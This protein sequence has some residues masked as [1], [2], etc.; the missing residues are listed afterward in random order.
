MDRLPRLC[1]SLTRLGV[2]FRLDILGVGPAESH[3]R[4]E[5]RRFP[6]S[7]LGYKTGASYW[8]HLGNWDMIVFVSDVEGLGISA[9]EGMSVGVLPLYPATGGA[10]PYVSKVK[11]SLLYPTGDIDALS[12][13]IG[14]LR[15][16]PEHEIAELRSRCR[17]VIGP[18]L[19]DNYERFFLAFLKET[20]DRER[21]SPERL[22][23]SI[24]PSD[25]LPFGI[26]RR[27]Y[28]KSLADTR[29]RSPQPD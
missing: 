25:F 4:Q 6:V 28:P 15:T 17:E 16:A 3:L 14:G 23:R 7:F 13:A 20:I 22:L 5:L 18:H 2:D 27:F 21:T 29:I 10:A 9:L 26:L 12:A 1:E 24:H 11:N 19:N 8:Q